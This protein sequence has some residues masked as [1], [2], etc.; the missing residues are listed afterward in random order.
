MPLKDYFG[1]KLAGDVIYYQNCIIKRFGSNCIYG[2]C[3]RLP[4]SP[5]RGVV[6]R[7]RISPRIRSQNRNSWK[8]S[9]RDLGQSV[10]CKNLGKF[11][12]LPCPFKFWTKTVVSIMYTRSRNKLESQSDQRQKLLK[13]YHCGR[14]TIFRFQIFQTGDFKEDLNIQYTKSQICNRKQI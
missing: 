6:F 1:Q 10:L 4:D 9:V 7:I 2:Q 3:C 14:R 13:G 11:S 12:S 5:I 8:C